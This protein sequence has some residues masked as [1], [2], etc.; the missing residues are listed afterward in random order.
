M[1]EG[2]NRPSYDAGSFPDIQQARLDAIHLAGYPIDFSR[3]ER[4]SGVRERIINL[5]SG[6]PLSGL[7]QAC[8]V[9]GAGV[10]EIPGLVYPN[11]TPVMRT[12]LYEDDDGRGS[13]G[14]MFRVKA[15]VGISKALN[16]SILVVPSATERTSTT[17]AEEL[18]LFGVPRTN[19]DLETKARTSLENLVGIFAMLGGIENAV[20]VSSEFHL[21]RVE[22]M[23]RYLLRLWSRQMEGNDAEI[24]RVKNILE[25]L[26]TNLFYCS[27]EAVL[28][29]IDPAFAEEFERA[30][31]L[32]AYQKRLIN[33]QQGYEDIEKDVYLSGLD[34]KPILPIQ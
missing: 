12:T 25:T 34:P 29:I 6:P 21:P 3:I 27:A 22:L 7:P 11:D 20:I 10:T 1:S 33:E 19:V 16:D 2:I 26:Q 13:L 24:A 9:L 18:V 28:T 15:A 4:N 31:L 8:F 14:G 23:M 5:V 30:K 32:P 17:M